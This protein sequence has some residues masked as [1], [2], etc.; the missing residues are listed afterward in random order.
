[1]SYS[2][3][4]SIRALEED[5]LVCMPASS[6]TTNWQI[7]C[8]FCAILPSSVKGGN[9]MYNAQSCEDFLSSYV[10]SA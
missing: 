4:L 10:L 8:T 7:T 1:M 3:W 6:L 5:Y 9:Y 2:W